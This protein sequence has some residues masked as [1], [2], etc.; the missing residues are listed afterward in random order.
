VLSAANGA[1]LSEGRVL[2]CWKALTSPSAQCRKAIA[3]LK[4]KQRIEE[5]ERE[6]ERLKNQLL[7]AN[8]QIDQLRILNESFA[9]QI[10]QLK[11][12]KILK[13]C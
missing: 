12:P 9:Q 5:L 13:R 11:E 3:M 6:N 10:R 2:A 7:S 1:E 8:E 4:Q